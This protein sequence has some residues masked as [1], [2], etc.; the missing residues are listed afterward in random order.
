M[1]KA[2]MKKIALALLIVLPFALGTWFV[3][4]SAQAEDPAPK[5]ASS[6]LLDRGTTAEVGKIPDK[7]GTAPPTGPTPI[8]FPPASPG[9]APAPPGF[10]LMGAT[11]FPP[12]GGGF[13]GNLFLPG[14]PGYPPTFLTAGATSGFDVT[15][16][17]AWHLAPTPMA[18]FARILG[19]AA[20]VPP[21]TPMAPAPVVPGFAIVTVSIGTPAPSGVVSAPGAFAPPVRVTSPS[22]GIFCG[23]GVGAFGFPPILAGPAGNG[24]G[25]ISGVALPPIRTAPV[26]FTTGAPVVTIL[27]P[28][29]AYIAG[30]FADSATTPVELQAFHVE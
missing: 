10:G 24:L 8:F 16:A 11:A 2:V 7:G 27:A 1:E 28:P 25:A 29:G 3:G 13:V 22:V 20:V 19:A 26:P 30:C 15:G 17:F 12:A 6:H 5:A 21:I 9:A 4:P 14:V 23:L 18:S